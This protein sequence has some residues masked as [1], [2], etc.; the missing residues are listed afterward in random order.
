MGDVAVKVGKVVDI[1]H[2]DIN[3]LVRGR[4]VPAVAPWREDLRG[5]RQSRGGRVG[6]SLQEQGEA[7]EECG[8]ESCFFHSHLRFIGD[9]D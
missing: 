7:C 2:R 3:A 5:R 9:S 8:R 6:P 1:R 4:I